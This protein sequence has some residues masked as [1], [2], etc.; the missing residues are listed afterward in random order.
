MLL[1]SE[2]PRGG[3]KQ[4]EID[5]WTLTQCSTI[6]WSCLPPKACSEFILL[7]YHQIKSSQDGSERQN[8]HTLEFKYLAYQ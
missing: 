4:R 2:G 1:L 6:Q 3:E 5:C 8:Q 7:F